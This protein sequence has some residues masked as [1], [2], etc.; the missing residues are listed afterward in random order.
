[1]GGNGLLL[2]SFPL[3]LLFLVNLIRD[4]NGLWFAIILI[5]HETARL[6]EGMPKSG[7]C[8]LN[9]GFGIGMVRIL[10]TFLHCTSSLNHTLCRSTNI[11]KMRNPQS[12]SSYRVT[13][14][15]W[16]GC[17]IQI[18]WGYASSRGGGKFLLPCNVRRQLGAHH[19]QSPPQAGK[20]SANSAGLPVDIGKFDID[21][22]DKGYHGHFSFIRHVPRLLGGPGSRFSYFNS[23]W[24]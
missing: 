13:Q 16:A 14:R 20:S 23:K 17:G 21:T 18:A 7:L 19:A 8:I 3:G 24:Q 12:T 10:D 4:Q 1:M 6:L 5:V 15:A 2:R 11:S 22:F 9:I